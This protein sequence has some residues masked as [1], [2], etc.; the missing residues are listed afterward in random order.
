[1]SANIVGRCQAINLIDN[2]PKVAALRFKNIMRTKNKFLTVKV[3]KSVKQDISSD[4]T[5][6]TLVKKSIFYARVVALNQMSLLLVLFVVEKPS[7]TYEERLH[8]LMLG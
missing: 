7:G 8:V 2:H 1:M 5:R 3:R 6:I 4:S